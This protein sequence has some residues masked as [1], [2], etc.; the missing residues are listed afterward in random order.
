[1]RFHKPIGIYLLLWPTCWALWL[2]SAGHPSLSTVFIF[3]SGTILMRAAGCIIN[4]MADRDIDP[5]VAR[6]HSRPLASKELS[7]R[8][9][10]T[11]CI[12]LLACAASLLFFLPM[13]CFYLA[14][15][16][17]GLTILYPF[18][19]RFIKTPQCILGLAFSWGIPM[20]YAA[21]LNHV[22][23]DAYYLMGITWLWIV[24]YDTLYA[25]ADKDDDLKIGVNSTAIFFGDYDKLI[26]L[27]FQSVITFAWLA[28]AI[29][30]HF[31]PVFYL[32]LC[33]ASSLFVYQQCLIREREPNR[34][35]MAFLNNHWYG[36]VIWM[37]ILAS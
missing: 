2:S 33:V 37:G 7:V 11:L 5:H 30:H 36:F 13:M 21:N 25:M 6:T 3:I 22:P 27:L 8:Y 14:L 4:D 18:C 29:T 28:F 20:A 12:T 23:V 15:I 34:C 32:F 9:A 17:V 16:G 1:M 19:K 26:I 35:F 10:L 31:G 24:Q